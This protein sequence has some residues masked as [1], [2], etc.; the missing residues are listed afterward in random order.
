MKVK[1]IM[2]SSPTFCTPETVVQAAAK[3]MCDADCGEI[4]V[5]ENARSMKP[6]G[7]ITDRDIACRAV[8][9]GK[10]P[11]SVRVSECMT[12]PAV[13]VSPETEAEECLDTLERNRIRRILVADDK[14]RCVGIVSQADV[15]R[16]LGK[17]KAGELVLEVSSAP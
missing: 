3:M 1:E 7:V 11:R 4:P 6:V 5:L 2:T 15:A 14:G 10:D 9:E 12:S 17:M 16:K 13:S 8:A